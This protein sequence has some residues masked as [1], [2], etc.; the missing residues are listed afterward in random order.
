MK[1]SKKKI[2]KARVQGN[3]NLAR[4]LELENALEKKQ[5]NEDLVRILNEFSNKII[6]AMEE[7]IDRGMTE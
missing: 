3:E 6:K 1:N 7:L 5:S 2:I 4:I